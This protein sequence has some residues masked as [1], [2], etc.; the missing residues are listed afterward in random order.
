MTWK[1]IKSEKITK[2]PNSANYQITFKED[3][4]TQIKT[5]GWFK[6]N[7]E[8]Q[9]QTEF[10]AMIKKEVKNW[11]KYLNQKSVIKDFKL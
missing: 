10:E 11:L 8:K 4:K 3:D 6:K 1:I 9:T 7:D 2:D 5:Y